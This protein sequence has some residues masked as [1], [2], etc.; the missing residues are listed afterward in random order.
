MNEHRSIPVEERVRRG[1][2]EALGDTGDGRTGVA[3]ET[4]GISNRPGDRGEDA[5]SRMEDDGFALA[6]GADDGQVDDAEELATG[7]EEEEEEDDDDDDDEEDEEEDEVN[8]PEA[9]PG[10]PI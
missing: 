10:K 5:T 6:D 7:E 2:S 8:D 9:E 4:Q 1:Q 3:P